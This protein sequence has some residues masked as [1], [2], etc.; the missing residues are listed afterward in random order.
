MAMEVKEINS[1]KMEI[2]EQF[3]CQVT[4]PFSFFLFL[5]LCTKSV[6]HGL[7]SNQISLSNGSM[8]RLKKRPKLVHV[9]ENTPH[10]Q[11]GL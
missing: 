10:Q 4:L 7:I 11:I 5:V 3:G 1:F 8:S 9:T 6:L 2:C